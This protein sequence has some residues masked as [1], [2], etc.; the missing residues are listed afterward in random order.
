MALHIS[1]KLVAVGLV[2]T[3]LITAFSAPRGDEDGAR[4][5]LITP[6]ATVRATPVEAAHALPVAVGPIANPVYVVRAT[7]YNS[8]ASQTDPTPHITAT[9]ERTRFGVIAV[10]RDLLGQ[11]LPYGSLVRL[12]DLGNYYSGRGY[13]RFQSLLDGQGLFVVEDT[14]HQ[15]KR[16]QVDI[17]FGDYASAVNWGVRKVRVE[18]VRYG[19]S[20]PELAPSEA[21]GFTGTPRLLAAR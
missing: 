4:S 1:G 2:I 19:R 9:G 15:R 18:V 7:G 10:S 3:A 11:S 20:G 12:T 17:W 8:M 13:G 16:D 21:T 14:M 6:V 5:I